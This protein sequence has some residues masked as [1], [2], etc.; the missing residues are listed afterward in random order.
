ML[1]KVLVINAK[2]TPSHRSYLSSYLI[3]ITYQRI[4]I[5]IILL[6]Y[7]SGDQERSRSTLR[8]KE[9]PIMMTNSKKSLP[10]KNFRHVRNAIM[11]I[12]REKLNARCATQVFDLPLRCASHQTVNSNRA[13]NMSDP[14]GGTSS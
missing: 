6:N 14:F 9:K 8:F 13:M 4:I 5:C 7:H 12:P 1:G 11:G 10:K 3:Q 2:K